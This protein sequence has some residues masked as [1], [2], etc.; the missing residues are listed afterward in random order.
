[1]TEP[2]IVTKG[3]SVIFG[4][5]SALTGLDLSIHKGEI[6]AL[7]GPNGA[8]KTTAFNAITGAVQPLTG[9]ATYTCD[10]RP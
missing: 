4:G 9:A 1:M 5:L 6:V 3:L 7:I 2:L 10:G 8:G